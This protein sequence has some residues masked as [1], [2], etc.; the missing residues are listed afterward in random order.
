MNPIK[1]LKNEHRGIETALRILERVA[2]R[3]GQAPDPELVIDG[4]ALID[5]FRTFADTCHHGKEEQLLF[6]A[7][8]QLGVSRQGRV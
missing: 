4:E 3:F 7:L 5:F 6:P 8:E 1:D 2:N